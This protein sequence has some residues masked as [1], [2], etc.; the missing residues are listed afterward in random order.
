MYKNNLTGYTAPTMQLWTGRVDAEVPSRFYQTV[1]CL[2]LREPLP[3][4][5]TQQ[6]HFAL[7][8]FACDEGV[9]RNQGRVGAA[10][11]PDAFRAAFANLPLDTTQASALYDVGTIHCVGKN[12]EKA[13]KQLA[14]VVCYL[15]KNN[16]KPLVIGGGHE[17]AWGHY[18]GIQQ[19]LHPSRLSIINFDAHFD[20]R[21]LINGKLGSSGTP[22]LQIAKDRQQ[23]QLPF[24]YT[25][26]GIQKT[27]NTPGL[28]AMAH[29]LGVKYTL[30][31]TLYWQP[32]AEVQA[33]LKKTLD[34][35][36]AL[37]I[38]LCLDVFAE[39]HAPGVSATQS[40]GLHPWQVIGLLRYLLASGKV[41]S[42]DI[43]ELSPP[44]DRNH[45]T[46]K[47][48]ASLAFEYLSNVNSR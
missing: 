2:D 32:L 25:C 14:K 10:L 17:T 40:L 9:R 43:V 11:G 37:Y 27:A 6:N 20:L 1:R 30:A 31:E 44:Y 13:Q 34:E 35:N 15:L 47:L 48:A 36:D 42:L 28:F 45:I 41:V 29:E 5:P 23:Q 38:T 3:L 39:C 33:S 22:F 4:L 24:D 18:Q 12:L 8:G 21:P 19:A 26:I 16:L 46:A 7:I